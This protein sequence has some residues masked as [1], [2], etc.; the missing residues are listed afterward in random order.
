MPRENR[1]LWVWTAVLAL[2]VSVAR[3]ETI[4]SNFGPGNTY[5]STNGFPMSIEQT[6]NGS[7]RFWDWAMTFTVPA[8]QSYRLDS[9]ALALDKSTIPLVIGPIE[10]P[11]GTVE[12][13]L[14]SDEGGFPDDVIETMSIS[15]IPSR[16]P[17]AIYTALSTDRPILHAG[18]TY[19]ISGH[20]PEI[21]SSIVWLRP[22]VGTPNAPVATR[23]E[24]ADWSYWAPGRQGAYMVTATAVPEIP[25]GVLFALGGGILIML[26]GSHACKSRKGAAQNV[27]FAPRSE[28]L[29][30]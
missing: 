23:T 29:S 13:S 25:A 27:A 21:T 12:L 16:V 17:P 7:T 9:I 26:A 15:G 2:Q 6:F 18:Q 3:S 28:T 1:W 20:T 14:M 19:W 22:P 30:F 11:G 4:F 8:G 10:L 24:A 5:D